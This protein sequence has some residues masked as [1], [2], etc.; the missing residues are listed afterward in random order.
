[1][2]SHT[3][4]LGYLFFYQFGGIENLGYFSQEIRKFIPLY[5]LKKFS[6]FWLEKKNSQKKKT[7]AR[8]MNNNIFC[9]NI[10]GLGL[11]L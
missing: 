5:T 11:P 4:I 6:I 1:M 2:L 7:I 8:N 10:L 9:S 3:P